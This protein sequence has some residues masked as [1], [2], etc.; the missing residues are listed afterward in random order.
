EDAV[1]EREARPQGADQGGNGRECR[2]GA[3]H[4]ADHMDANEVGREEERRER[5]HVAGGSHE[6]GGH[7]VHVPAEADRAGGDTERQAE[8][9]RLPSEP[10]MLPRMPMA[11]GTNTSK[12]G[13]AER[14]WVMAP[15]VSPARRSPPDETR[16][17]ASAC[18]TSAA[19][20][21]SVARRRAPRPRRNR[22]GM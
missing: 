21:P 13:R 7:V 2:D 4:R 6:R 3:E 15:S 11:A 12:P 14:V 19:S 8:H 5:H 22:A 18:R 10:K 9:G 1:E 17:A 16:R 20:E